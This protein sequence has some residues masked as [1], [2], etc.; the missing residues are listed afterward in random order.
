MPHQCTT[1][2]KVFPDGSKEMLSGCPSCGGNKFQFQPASTTSDTGSADGSDNTGASDSAG[3]QDLTSSAADAVR[4]RAAQNDARPTT[5]DEETTVQDWVNS[6]SQPTRDSPRDSD[7]GGDPDSQRGSDPQRS[8]DSRREPDRQPPQER[9]PPQTRTDDRADSKRTS[10]DDATE[11]G[12][13]EWPSQSGTEPEPAS[14]R[15][16]R[17]DAV[18]STGPD[19]G[20]GSER[21]TQR[22]PRKTNRGIRARTEDEEDNSQRSARSDVVTPEELAALDSSR[23]NQ[24]DKPQRE[25]PRETTESQQ[26]PSNAQQPPSDAQQPPS[27]A[28]QPPSEAQQPPSDPQQPQVDAPADVPT[29]ADGHV[30]EPPSDDRPDLDQLREELNDQFESIKIVNPGQYELNLMELYDRDEYIISLREDGRYVIEVPDSWG[31]GD[32]DD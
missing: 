15:D 8:S 25:P 24:D 1:C 17:P 26:P 27:E 21:S 13:G 23:R 19:P 31:P 6:Q 18:S 22:S 7:A 28:Q 32:R 14:A 12:W 20:E 16:D 30:V 11:R 2:G 5:E 29:D 10:K 3:S 9:Q 4:R